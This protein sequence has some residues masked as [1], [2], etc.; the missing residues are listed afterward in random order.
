MKALKALTMLL[1]AGSVLSCSKEKPASQAVSQAAACWRVYASNEL[2]NDLTVIAEPAH[3]VLATIAI[4]KRPRGT[5]LNGDTL[6]V[7]LSGWPI[8]GPGVDEDKLPPPDKSADGIAVLDTASLKV[9]RVIHGVENPE[10]LAVSPDNKMLYV[11]NE[12]AGTVQFVGTDGSDHGSVKT[13]SSPEGVAVSAD[14]KMLYVSSEGGGLVTVIDTAQAKAIQGIVAG[15]RPRSVIFSHD[16]KRAYVSAEQGGQLVTIDT[17][18]RAVTAKTTI[19]GKDS[20]PMGLAVSP[21]DSTVYVSTG[22]GGTLVKVAGGQQTA[23]TV[24]GRPWGI[25]AS[26][27]G[28]WIY[29]ADGPAG[30]V[31]VVDAAKMQVVTKIKVG[32]RPWGVRVG[33]V[34]GGKACD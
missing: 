31:A 30:D 18:A 29:T 2:S 5:A 10:Q 19:E 15:D 28:K 11:A 17:A 12:D 20:K 9:A 7:A 21:D 25:A 3:K 6:Y 27:D 13:G 26:P 14:G 8:A 32:D 4:G 1:L 22:R 34:P 23:V 24:G 16:G 33:P